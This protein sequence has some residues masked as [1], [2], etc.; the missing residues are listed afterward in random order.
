MTQ[1]E[2]IA[3]AERA[4]A[5]R[6]PVMRRLIRQ[7]GPATLGTRRQRSHFGALVRAIVY[8]QL[9]GRAAAAIHGR[10]LALFDRG[11]L[12]PEGVLALSEPQMRA[13]GLSGAKVASIRDLAAKSLDGTV[14]LRGFS[15]LSDDEIVER[16]SS[17]GGIGRWTA[18]MF[19]LFQLARPDV[20]PV[21]DLGVRNGYRIAYE[22]PAMPTPKELLPLGEAYRPY[23]SIAAWYCW[24]AVHIARGDMLTP[25]G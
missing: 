1:Q 5:R 11:R 6:D 3:K 8:Q 24:Q 12:S 21:D 18:E 15:R 19:L 7:A 17:V 25:G 10:F 22:L 13:A 16:L 4:L 23:R 14:P 2:E 9:A 20:W